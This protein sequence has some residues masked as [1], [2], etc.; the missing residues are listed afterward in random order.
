MHTGYAG[1]ADGRK[2]EGVC[3][4]EQEPRREINTRTK[5]P[6]NTEIQLLALRLPFSMHRSHTPRLPDR[7]QRQ[8]A[9]DVHKTTAAH[10]I[11]TAR[12]EPGI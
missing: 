4:H 6:L 7:I 10:T 11:F 3:V 12:R 1:R 9:M 2:E 5:S 8:S